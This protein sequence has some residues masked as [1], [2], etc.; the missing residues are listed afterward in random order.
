MQTGNVLENKR[1]THIL[2]DQYYTMH[3]QTFTMLVCF[4]P[5]EIKN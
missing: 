1:L 4:M 2:L 3:L 5:T